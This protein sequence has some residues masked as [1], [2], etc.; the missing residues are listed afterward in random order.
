MAVSKTTITG[1]VY[2]P[3]CQKPE[4]ARI[5][6]ELSS[7]DREENEAVFVTGPY[8]GDMDEY[9]D[10]EVELFT[11]TKGVNGVVYRASVVY[12][13]ITG[14]HK[15]E[16]IGY[17]TL[18]GDGPFCLADLDIVSEYTPHTFDALT[19]IAD[20]VRELRLARGST[21]SEQ[22]AVS[23]NTA[24]ALADAIDAVY[25]TKA[26]ANAA[27]SGLS[28]GDKVLVRVDENAAGQRSVYE[29]VSNAY[30]LVISYPAKNT[31][32]PSLT[33]TGGANDAIAA[34]VI[35]TGDALDIAGYATPGDGGGFL[36][37]V[38][39]GANPL[40]PDA[41]NLRV[42]PVSQWTD[43]RA[44]GA[45]GDASED[46][47]AAA[48]AAADSGLPIFI[49]ADFVVKYST[50]LV[51]KAPWIGSGKGQGLPGSAT[52]NA[53]AYETSELRFTGTGWAV[54]TRA[55]FQKIAVRADT[56]VA[57]QSGVKFV[58]GAIGQIAGPIRVMEFDGTGVEIGG[59]VEQSGIFF[60]DI[61]GIEV[62]NNVRLGELGLHVIGGG[63]SSANA[64]TFTGG[65]VSGPWTVNLK[66]QGNNNTFLNMDVNP[67][68]SK[69]AGLGGTI[70][71]GVIIEGDGNT[72]INPYFEPT[73]NEDFDCLIRFASTA[74]SN[75]ISR[76]YTPSAGNQIAGLIEDF[77]VANEVTIAD[78]GDNFT[79]SVGV[80]YSEDN[81]IPNPGFVSP[82]SATIPEGWV[83]GGGSTGTV[84]VD[85]SVTRR[86]ARTLKLSTA[87]TRAQVICYLL[88]ASSMSVRNAIQYYPAALFAK[89]TLSVGVWCKSSTS[90][91]GS[92]KVANGTATLGVASHS[93]SGDWE[94]LTVRARGI[95]SPTEVTI[96]LRNNNNFHNTTGD[97]WF[98][99]PVFVIGNDIPK[100]AGTRKIDAEK[101]VT[102]GSFS[103]NVPRDL[104]VDDATPDVSEG[105]L[106][107]EA[108]TA[109]TTITN[110]DGGR[111]GQEL[112]L[113]ATSANT[114]L[115]NNGNIKTNTGSA[116]GLE[117]NR[118]YRLVL[119][120][121]AWWEL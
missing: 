66:V 25:D 100:Y 62:D 29:V 86:F 75:L 115:A 70:D 102:L 35:H 103:W 6:F 54:T 117:A 71:A 38:E 5:V 94:F 106:W 119:S 34:G 120:N 52:D 116:K 42:V 63:A 98:S 50:P 47:T 1:P 81:L 12:V 7:W 51:L 90:G 58:G 101:A 13:T 33:G 14:E 26:L 92:V 80:G 11:T 23:A 65:F 93:G 85:T 19:E 43:I 3:N 84:T 108:N 37:V 111:E 82:D 32:W 44:F 57:G 95:D 112:I 107:R 17:F 67:K 76:L 15:R 121:G 99:E 109:A 46:Q 114:T 28:N 16:Y 61:S 22:A 105:S 59:S 60:A 89:Q 87:D 113:T 69:V 40:Y 27:L 68:P 97:C 36:G 53:T 21:Y 49:P 104:P 91:V 83:L 41:P 20:H 64:N 118:A 2:L 74:H 78:L 10:F 31:R 18:L 72:F 9:G 56:G 4:E 39:A 79:P 45:S 8:V 30:Q 55:S 48:V 73:P 77:G 110:F 24:L 88:S 96:A